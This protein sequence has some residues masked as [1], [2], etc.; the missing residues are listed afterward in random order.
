MT[1]QTVSKPV[2]DIL[3]ERG[4]SYGPFPGH[5]LVTQRIKDVMR[6][7]EGPAWDD[8]AP[9]VKAMY[10]EALDMIAH[11]IGRLVN[12]DPS[13][14]DSWADIAGYAELPRKFAPKVAE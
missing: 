1:D 6:A 5:A 9:S 10:R 14:D 3:V 8:L 2:A 7:G 11:K 13:F 12:G 4:A